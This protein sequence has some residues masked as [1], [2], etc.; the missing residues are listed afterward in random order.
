[1]ALGGSLWSLVVLGGSCWLLAVHGDGFRWSLVV[2]G[3]SWLFM[4]VLMFLGG[5]WGH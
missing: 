4:M 3:C 1:M 5:S 2:H